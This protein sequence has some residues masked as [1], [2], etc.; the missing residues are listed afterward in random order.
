[1]ELLHETWLPCRRRPRKA[2]AICTWTKT[3]TILPRQTINAVC[4]SETSRNFGCLERFL[5][6]LCG[7]LLRAIAVNDL[8]VL[9][10][11]L[12]GLVLLNVLCVTIL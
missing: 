10:L 8:L 4:G 2:L 12:T 1:M 5:L 6:F 3:H 11:L 7:L 9:D